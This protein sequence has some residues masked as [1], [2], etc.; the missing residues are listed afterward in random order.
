M[1]R[2]QMS[3][4]DIIVALINEKLFGMVECDIR[5]PDRLPAHLSHPTM[6]HYEY[7]SEMSPLF[8]TSDIPFDVIGHHMQNH[9]KYFHLSDKLRRLLVGGMRA[10]QLIIATL[11]LKWFISHGLDV[12]K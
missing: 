9:A 8:C 2:G 10:R 12:T 6:T 11:L 1:S 4:E 3:M 5:V 7:F